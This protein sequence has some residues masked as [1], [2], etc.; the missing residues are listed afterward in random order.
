MCATTQR[1]ERLGMDAEQEFEKNQ[2]EHHVK[3]KEHVLQLPQQKH[4]INKDD[5]PTHYS[6]HWLTNSL[7]LSLL[8]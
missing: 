6:P 8:H 1:Q 5:A 7:T 4:H 3:T 2:R